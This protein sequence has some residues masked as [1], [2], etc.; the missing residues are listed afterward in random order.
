[1]PSHCAGSGCRWGRGRG[2]RACYLYIYI[3]IVIYIDTAVFPNQ[4]YVRIKH[5]RVH[6]SRSAVG[7]SADLSIAILAQATQR[8]LLA[9][10]GR[11]P[12]TYHRLAAMA[13]GTG[14]RRVDADHIREAQSTLA[15]DGAAYPASYRRAKLGRCG[16]A[17]GRAID[18]RPQ[19]VFERSLAGNSQVGF[20]QAV[21]QTWHQDLLKRR[22]S[23]CSAGCTETQPGGPILRPLHC[24]VPKNL[25]QTALKY[26]RGDTDSRAFRF[27][28]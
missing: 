23:S 16:G 13:T 21:K 17:S 1:V 18:R 3:Y 22:G 27:N 26:P 25:D 2:G 8:H 28:L 7:L 5:R 15:R 4:K 10:V 19:G 11:R 6:P 12:P 14:G 20:R 9:N 24:M